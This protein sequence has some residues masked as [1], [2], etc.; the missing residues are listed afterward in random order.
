MSLYFRGLLKESGVRC[1]QKLIVSGL[2]PEQDPYSPNW[3]DEWS[4]DVVQWTSIED[5]DIFS[6]FISRPGTFT[7]EQLAS[8]K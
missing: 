3:S 6:Y 4:P 2:P 5:G 1:K 7:M 8:W